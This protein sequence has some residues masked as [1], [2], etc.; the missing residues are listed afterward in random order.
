MTSQSLS[1]PVKKDEI[2]KPTSMDNPVY[3][4]ARWQNIPV[5][6]Q[7]CEKSP[8]AACMT[9]IFLSSIQEEYT[10][11]QPGIGRPPDN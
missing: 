9:Y 7:N 8:A 4:K 10:R 5:D 6:P 1:T 3:N 11:W 2:F